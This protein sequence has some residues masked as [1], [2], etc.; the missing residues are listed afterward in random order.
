M[1]LFESNPSPDRQYWCAGL[2]LDFLAQASDTSGEFT[3]IDSV[4]KQGLEPPPH[5]HTYEDE[6]VLVVEGRLYY[7][8]GSQ[9]GTLNPGEYVKMPKQQEHYFRPIGEQVRLMVRLSPGGLEESF[10]AFGVPVSQSPTMPPPE[11]VPG[12]PVIAQI[13]AEVGVV[14]TPG[15]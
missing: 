3:L 9:E 11:A 8:Y 1:T 10:K 13:F 14:F 4:V 5:T 6:E 7:R 2:L 15:K 12:F